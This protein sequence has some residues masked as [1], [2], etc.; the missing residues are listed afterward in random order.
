[1]LQ[2]LFGAM[3]KGGRVGFDPVDWF[4]GGLFD[5]AD[6]LPLEVDD[7][8]TLR[9]LAGLDWSA[10]EPT[11]FGTLFERGLDPDKR[12]QLGAHYTDRSSIMRL[13]DPVVLDPLRAAWTARK[14]EIA[15]L[16]AKATAAKSLSARTKA[17]NEAHGFLQGF[18][19]RLA[20]SCASSRRS[21][22]AALSSS[23]SDSS[24]RMKAVVAR[25]NT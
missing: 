15:A 25:S 22:P 7:I 1:M 17:R 24:A 12:S 8:R 21:R 11:I 14:A 19:A 6:T 18:L 16:M 4:N 20:Q 23:R 3:A 5:S 10:I 13:V 9:A 2:D